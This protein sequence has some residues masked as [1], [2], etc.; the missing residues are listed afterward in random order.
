MSIIAYRQDISGRRDSADGRRDDDFL[1]VRPR[2][3][4]TF[5]PAP[6][7]SSPGGVAAQSFKSLAVLRSGGHSGI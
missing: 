2:K 5:F 4:T 3:C 7:Q 1:A 6:P